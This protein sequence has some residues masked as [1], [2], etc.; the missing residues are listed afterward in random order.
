MCVCMCVLMG[1]YVCARV[2]ACAYVCV[3]VCMCVFSTV[4]PHFSAPPSSLAPPGPLVPL[5]GPS[6][7]DWPARVPGPLGSLEVEQDV[8][9]QEPCAHVKGRFAWCRVRTADA[10]MWHRLCHQEFRPLVVAFYLNFF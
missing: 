4:L 1:V 9:P 8:G 6:Q 2:C 7:E 3:H 10:E 5:G